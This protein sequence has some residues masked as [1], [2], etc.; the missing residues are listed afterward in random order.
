MKSIF[1]DF[2]LSG[3][4]STFKNENIDKL[5]GFKIHSTHYSFDFISTE[6]ES[7]LLSCL[8]CVLII[9]FK[10]VSRILE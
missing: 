5:Y 8:I 9:I 7:L 3:L 6:E 1:E 2:L 4:R 10:Y